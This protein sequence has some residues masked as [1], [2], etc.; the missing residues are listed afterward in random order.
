MNTNKISGPNECSF[1]TDRDIANKKGMPDELWL[2]IFSYCGLYATAQAS[3][4]CRSWH[5]IAREIEPVL[6]SLSQHASQAFVLFGPPMHGSSESR[7]RGLSPV[8]DNRFFYV[9]DI[10]NQREIYLYDCLKKKDIYVDTYYDHMIGVKGLGDITAFFFSHEWGLYQ[11][12]KDTEEPQLVLKE[13]YESCDR[14]AIDPAKGLIAAVVDSKKG[15]KVF[16]L[17]GVLRF[18]TTQKP[19]DR[20]WHLGFSAQALIAIS[21]EGSPHQCSYQLYAYSL[22]DGHLLDS[23]IL[24]HSVLSM[25]CSDTHIAIIECQNR[26]EYALQTFAANSLQPQLSIPLKWSPIIRLNRY[27]PSIEITAG[28]SVLTI[29]HGIEERFDLTTGQLLSIE[30]HYNNPVLEYESGYYSDRI[31]SGDYS[32]IITDD[33]TSIELMNHRQGRYLSRLTSAIGKI[34]GVCFQKDEKDALLMIGS[35]EGEVQIWHSRRPD[36]PY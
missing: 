11:Q 26:S 12:K 36:S 21:L 4:A 22:E 34:S 19:S 6:T 18:Q 32:A 33:H 9:K 8:V 20:I 5:R 16:D 28:Q 27:E 1:E 29:L 35:K 30:N 10:D 24:E 3:L 23:H 14:Y 31:T 13:K 2:L 17:Q 25:A 7:L 15:I